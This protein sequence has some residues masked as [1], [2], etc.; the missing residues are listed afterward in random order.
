MEP[1]LEGRRTVAFNDFTLKVQGYKVGL[2][3]QGEADSGRHQE[4]FPVGDACAD[5]TE[6]LDEFLMRE[7][8]AGADDVLS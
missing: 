1:R 8:P 4:K 3:N 2:L 7:D 6:A 5:V